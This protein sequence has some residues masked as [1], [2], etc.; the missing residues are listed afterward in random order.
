MGSFA[1]KII[2]S[3]SAISLVL[4]MCLQSEG[5][6]DKPPYVSAV[7]KA[8]FATTLEEQEKQL[9]SDPLVLRFAESRKRQ[10][11]DPYRPIYHF[12]SPES[13]LND[14]NGLCFWQGNW[15]M[16]YQAYPPE[17]KRQHWGHAISK[18]LIHWRDL[19]YAIYPSPERAV[20]S[21]A[22]MVED[23][24]VIAIY[25]GTA[26]GNM[27]AIA[28]DPLLLNWEKITGQVVIPSKGATGFSQPY[29]VFDPSIWKRDGVYYSLS[30][31]RRVRSDGGSFGSSSL[32]KSIDLATW[33]Y[34]HEFVEGD[35][36]TVKGDD[37]ACPYF[38]PIG[39]RYIMPFFS[40]MSGGQYML[41]DYNKE[42]DK[43]LV[44][45]H[46]KFNFGATGPAGVH[47]PSAT[48]DGKGG[49]IIIFN[50][51]PGKPTGEW[52]QIMTLPRKLTLVGKDDLRQEPAG[53]I[54]SLRLNKQVVGAMKLSGNK[55]IVLPNIKGTAMEI[56]AE[57]S[58]K[59]AQVVELNVLRSPNKEEYTRII[60]Y[61]DKGFSKGLEYK[62][63]QGTAMMPADLVSLVTGEKPVPRPPNP[64]LSL[65]S[66]ESSFS[67]TL[68]DV[69]V[70]PA[71]TAPFQLNPDE[72]VKL[73]IFIDK[74]VVE[75]F[76]NGKQC[77]AMRVYPGRED[78][79][80]VSILS[81]GQDAELSSLEA[82]QMKGI[83]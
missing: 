70:R 38:W 12:V 72:S 61:K 3:V 63:G 71:E 69:Q 23:N 20:F 6:P 11:K 36:F 57:I 46:G 26:V 43:F 21:G 76:V 10:S 14:P 77:V 39:D 64:R 56:S 62:S 79:T 42:E 27:V 16:F 67:S 34:V 51:N 49:V 31:G 45:G 28:N 22:T 78:S 73:R 52:N 59:G 44:S 47:A 15:H 25:H 9:K 2:E 24:R 8:T 83:Y 35:R 37:Y 65:I 68:P 18:D 5:Q 50:M 82:W 7:P 32:F 33:E 40:H 54:E 60:V 29:S 1:K 53:D 41:G 75:V 19:P 80:G 4:V 30:A 13:S 58:F 66:I 74:S 55:E 81:H 48:P 17:D